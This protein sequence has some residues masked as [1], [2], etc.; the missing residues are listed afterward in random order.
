[1]SESA[2]KVFISYRREDTAGHAGRLYDTMAA[3]FGQPNVFVDVDL[4]PGIDFVQ[5]ISEAVGEC[6]VLLVIIGPRWASLTDD[7][8]AI[9]IADPDDFVRLE[10]ETA[11][12]RAEVTVI[13]V[14]VAGAQMPDPDDLPEGVRPLTRR[15]ALELSDMRWRYDVGRLNTRLDEL[16]A[17]T[18]AVH[19][20]PVAEPAAEPAARFAS[21]ARL[22]AEGMAVAGAAALVARLLAEPIDPAE[23]ASA[24]G[25][26]A[27]AILRRTVTWA[28]LGA[29]LAAWLSFTRGEVRL[30]ATRILL[31]LAVGALAGALGGA[32]VALPQYLPDSELSRE[33][34][35]TIS[36]GA[37]AVSGALIGGLIGSLWTPRSI[38]TGVLAG[39]VGGALVR[40]L[41]NAVGFSTD[42]AIEDA[43]GI[44]IQCLLI[45]GL[46]LAA[47]QALSAQPRSTP[48][49]AH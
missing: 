12:R 22:F 37:F 25:Q 35:R 19:D 38:A 6:R 13:P 7:E 47:L 43:L 8:G 16:L 17:D 14:L 31:G 48:R 36:I 9:R 27:A 2:P 10:V 32:I 18:T 30:L 34:I 33:S 46:V 29:A 3:R 24:A 23:E 42:A 39:L 1:M 20:V 5:R 26:I 21:T 45:V 44:G 15:N 28:V 4:A 41:W 49:P 40:L 11:L